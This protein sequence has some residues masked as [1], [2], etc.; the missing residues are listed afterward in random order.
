MVRHSTPSNDLSN[1]FDRQKNGGART[2]R[3]QL[4]A[5]PGK[6]IAN[7]GH[8]PRKNPRKLLI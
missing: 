5:L 3:Q 1:R 7:T 6:A 2:N 4:A 8:W